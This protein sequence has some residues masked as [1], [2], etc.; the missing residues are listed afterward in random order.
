MAVAHAQRFARSAPKTG[1]CS[2][3][4]VN[5]VAYVTRLLWSGVPRRAMC[6]VRKPETPEEQE[7][8]LSAV[9]QATMGRRMVRLAVVA[10]RNHD[11]FHLLVVALVRTNRSFS[12]STAAVKEK[13]E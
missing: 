13:V 11:R 3:S 10:V 5:E 6:R 8:D 7:K 9:S 12:R 4:C 2:D 1:R